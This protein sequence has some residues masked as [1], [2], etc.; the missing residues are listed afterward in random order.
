MAAYDNPAFVEDILRNVAVRLREDPRIAW[1]DVGVTNFE[2]IHN[3][4][5]FARVSW[6]RSGA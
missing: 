4:N 2:S 3:H 5:A 1:F 6:E